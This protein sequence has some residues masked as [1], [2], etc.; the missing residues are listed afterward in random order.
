MEKEEIIEADGI[1][2]ESFP[3]AQFQVE[4]I[5]KDEKGNIVEQR[6]QVKAYISGKL[7]MN[8]IKILP[9]DWVRVEMSPYD[10][11]MA[12]ITWRYKEPPMVLPPVVDK[13]EDMGFAR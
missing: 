13:S 8:Y 5:L 11:S 6:P 2:L 10:P 4:L 12:R 7:R 1:V 3:N 9:S